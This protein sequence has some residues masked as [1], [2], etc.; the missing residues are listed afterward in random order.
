MSGRVYLE[1]LESAGIGM[2]SWV[3]DEM[4][5]LKPMAPG[6]GRQPEGDEF[7]VNNRSKKERPINGA[8][9]FN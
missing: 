2:T 5:M 4:H 9:F 6:T 1:A 3:P 7:G 8:L